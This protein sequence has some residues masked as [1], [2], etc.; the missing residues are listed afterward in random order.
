MEDSSGDKMKNNTLIMG[1]LALLVLAFLG[2]YISLPSGP[3]TTIVTGQAQSGTVYT[4]ELGAASTAYINAYTGPHGD[5][6]AKTE[7]YPVW[8][9]LDANGNL[10][11]NDAAA[12]SSSTAVGEKLSFYGTGATYY[13]DPLVNQEISTAAPTFDLNAYTVPTTAD[14]D[15][16]VYDETGA[17][18]LTADDN[19]NKSSD[20]DG[21]SLGAGETK[22]YFAK[23]TTKVADKTFRLG[24]ICTYT[25]GAE[26]DDF[27]LE[28]NDWE[29]VAVPSTLSGASPNLSDDGAV[30]T[31]GSFRH[32][33]VPKDKKYIALHEWD[34]V[35]YQFIID[36][37]DTT[38]P[39][40]NGDS[41]V[42]GVFM[43]TSW[44][45]DGSGQLQENWY[46]K[47]DG[48]EDPGAVGLD[49]NPETAYYGL[50]TSFAIEPH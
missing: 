36:T 25:I 5:A 23:F 3:Q 50:D 26:V 10:I 13:V 22:Q 46:K 34:F 35:K 29:E 21:G 18:A 9:V 14:M 4:K 48:T 41:Y 12:N 17:T 7:V 15:V 31:S 20:Y 27:T 43:D 6:G 2:G 32:C 38:G 33:Y 47:G 44:E 24:A 49:E 19:V 30:S 45:K 40:D 16:V 37:D 1:I 11:T 28:E 8:T 42:G 39:S